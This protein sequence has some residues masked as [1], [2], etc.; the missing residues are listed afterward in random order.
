MSDRRATFE[1]GP[2]F[3]DAPP[4]WTQPDRHRLERPASKRVAV[5]LAVMHTTLDA[6]AMNIAAVPVPPDAD[7]ESFIAATAAGIRGFTVSSRGSLDVRAATACPMV[8]VRYA[9]VEGQ[10]IVQRYVLVPDGVC[11]IAT[12]AATD[13]QA[14]DRTL[15]PVL[16]TFRF[17][18]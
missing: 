17:A 1:L 16:A 12:V 2:G 8:T 4:D 13:M 3:V 9:I 11:L 5:P 7:L 14:L 6:G 18:V 10:P 15:N